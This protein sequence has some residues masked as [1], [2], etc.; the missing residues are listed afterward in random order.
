[1]LE[2]INN[3]KNEIDKIGD[4]NFTEI[5]G[6]TALIVIDMVKGFCNLGPLSTPRSS[7]AINPIMHLTSI[8]KENKKVFFIDS[9]SEASIEFKSYPIHC[10]KG[11]EEAELIDELIGY[12]KDSSVTMI[13]KNSINGFHANKFKEWLKNN[14]NIKNFIV[15]GVCTDICVEVFTISLA[16]YFH[17]VNEDKNI[18]VPIN[19]V[20]T[21]DF[22]TH[23]GDLMN[24]ISLYKMNSNGIKVV[25]SINI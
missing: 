22:G 5:E 3:M 23:N 6:D 24:I 16:T 10:I 7:K 8:M 25:K 21:F 18:I 9:H 17:E 19:T 11:S 13:K 20:E 4:L 1:M 12:S 2:A 14:S 15:T